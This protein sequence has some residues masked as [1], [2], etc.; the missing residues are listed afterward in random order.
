MSDRFYIRADGNGTIGMGHVQRCLS[1]ANA[2]RKRGA[3]PIFLIADEEP[4]TWLFKAGFSYIVLGTDFRDMEA[5][6]SKIEEI[7]KKQP[8]PVL[9]DSYQITPEYMKRLS[10]LS[11]TILMSDDNDGRYDCHDLINYNIYAEDLSY[12]ETY[13]ESEYPTRF[14]LG[15]RYAPLREEFSDRTR[16]EKAG[17]IR[18]VLLTTGGS[19]GCHL[20]LLF[21]K[22]VAEGRMPKPCEYHVLCGP[23]CEDGEELREIAQNVDNLVIDGPV[24]EMAPY[25]ETFDLVCSAAGSTLYEL[26]ALGIPAMAFTT[27]GNQKKNLQG[28]LT[29]SKMIGLGDAETDA[30][31]VLDQLELRWKELLAGGDKSLSD[32]AESMHRVTDG[33]GADQLANALLAG[34][35]RNDT[36]K[37]RRTLLWGLLLIL[38]GILALYGLWGAQNKK[39]TEAEFRALSPAEERMLDEDPELLIFGD[40][41]FAMARDH[42]TIPD[43][44]AEKTGLRIF[45]AAIGGSTAAS[46]NEELDFSKHMDAFGLWSLQEAI[47]DGDFGT[48]LAENETDLTRQDYFEIVAHRLEKVD[49]SRVRYVLI[50]YGSNDYTV[51]HDPYNK[52]DPDDICSLGCVLE[53]TIENLREAYPQITVILVTPKYCM[54]AGQDCLTTDYGGGVL[55]AYVDAIKEVGQKENVP[56][57]DGFYESGFNAENIMYYTSGEGLHL[58]REGV[59][60]YGDFLGEE[61]LKIIQ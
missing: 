4:V 58:N 54:I 52:E 9:V 22:R 16:G 20:G 56:V 34:E 39:K 13:G 47:L 45:N 21:A 2:L 49:L 43:R 12:E 50:A 44:I 46:A 48:I 59:I 1:L 25:L 23:F 55:T 19:D 8:G 3:D 10:S 14:Y 41:I 7:L 61:I 26:C 42:V 18:K 60:L 35:E 15:P 30:S 29:R 17:E 5:E 27:A 11:R 36:G 40:S 6:L 33:H 32:I 28:F 57:I 53:R 31:G 51:G 37:T 24:F 38:A